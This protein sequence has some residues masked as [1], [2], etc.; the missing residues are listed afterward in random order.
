MYLVSG[1]VSH[2]RLKDSFHRRIAVRY[3]NSEPDPLCLFAVCYAT[4]ICVA[5]VMLQNL[6]SQ[7]PSEDFPL[8]R[9]EVCNSE[10][11]KEF[12]HAVVRR[13]VRY[14][15][16]ICQRTVDVTNCCFVKCHVFSS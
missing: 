12:F 8:R 3:N 10:R 13:T 14:L 7:K 6:K 2:T 5:G 4:I 1:A 9:L 11:E 15:L 16:L